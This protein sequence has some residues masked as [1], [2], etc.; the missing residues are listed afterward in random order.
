MIGLVDNIPALL[1]LAPGL[2]FSLT[3]HEYAHARVALAF[4]D[5][6]AYCLGRVS[7]NPLRHLDP[8]GTIMIFLIGFGWAKPV[9]VNSANLRPPRLGDIAVSLAGVGSNFL[10][11]VILA[12]GFRILSV[13]GVF[14]GEHGKLASY[15]I[16][17]TIGINI[18]LCL[19][20]LIPLFPLDGHHVARELL[21]PSQRG[22][23]MEWQVR[24]GRIILIGFLVL[25]AFV[26]GMPDPLGIVFRNVLGPVRSWLVS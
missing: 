6:T 25:P 10:F 14:E 23:F 2:L 4:G 15:V 7:L 22:R 17:R 9:P 18:I 26:P 24:Y 20:N 16:L 8:I 19:F 5:P 13:S 1:A 21:P 12:A 3:I 11:A